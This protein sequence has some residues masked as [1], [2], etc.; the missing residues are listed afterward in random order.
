MSKHIF[1]LRL[2]PDAC[3]IDGAKFIR[4]PPPPS[5]KPYVLRLTLTAGTPACNNPILLTNYPVEERK[6][7][8]ERDYFYHIPF[9]HD[10]LG[11]ATCDVEIST[12]GVYKFTTEF[13][14]IETGERQKSL[15]SVS[16]V[17]DPCLYLPNKAIVDPKES[18][19]SKILLPLD[20]IVIL[21]LI[22]KWLP[23][24]SQW[25]SYF[26]AFAKT[27][28]NMI[29]FAPM[30]TRG[31]SNSPYAIY[32][33]LSLASEM[34]DDQISEDDKEVVLKYMLDNA[35]DMHGILSCTDIVWNHTACNSE[36][37]QD[38]P[39]A[40]Y[41]LKTAPHLRS[42]YELDEALMKFSDNVSKVYKL[43]P[44]LKTDSELG[45]IMKIF[46]QEVLPALKLWEYYVIDAESSCEEFSKAWNDPSYHVPND[47]INNIAPCSIFNFTQKDRVE[48][49]KK[50]CLLD[51]KDGK[52][53]SKTIDQ[54]FAVPFFKKWV[55][56][57]GATADS[58]V[59]PMKAYSQILNEINLL[60]YQEYDDDAACVVEQITS[61]ARYLRVQDHGPKLGSISR[62]NPLVDTYFTRLPV[63]EKTKHLHSDEMKLANN[64]WIWNAD[65]LVNFAGPKSK[66]YLRREVIAW[67]DCVKLRYGTG[68][69]DNPWL[70][71][72]IKR[73]TLKMARL[74]DGL[75]IDN[76]HSTP[77]HVASYFLDVARKHNPNIYVFAELFTGSEEK[78][79]TFVS[80]LGINSLIR[81]A[82]NA[83]E[84][85][86]LSRLAHKYGGRPSGSFTLNP[87]NI[88]LDILGHFM[89][90]TINSNK[91]IKP[92][93]I[94]IVKG[95][96]P[97]AL[98]MDCTHD[99]ETP[100]QKRTAEDT[101]PTAAIVAM[102][103]CAIGSVK[104]FDEIV[105]EL[106]N[107]VHET[108]K[109]RVPDMVEGIIPA[110]STFQSL[111]T[112]MAREG[113]N[114]VFVHHENDFVIIHRVHPITHDGYL[115]IARTAF[116]KDAGNAA[117]NP[118]RLQNQSV[119]VLEAASLKVEKSTDLK[120]N[121]GVFISKDHLSPP[122]SPSQ[123]YSHL[124]QSVKV[125]ETETPKRTRRQ[126]V[127]F[128]VITGL[129]STL[130]FSVNV[131]RFTK[132][133]IE[134]DFRGS[135]SIISIDPVE[136]TAGTVVLY[137]TWM[138]GTGLDEVEI[139]KMGTLST[140]EE[141]NGK[142]TP[143]YGA[144]ERLWSLLGYDT[145]TG[146]D[147]MFKMGWDIV[148]SGDLWFGSEKSQWPPGLM[149]A[150]LPLD[151]V[152]VNIVVFR[153]GG[154]ELNTTGDN[155]YDV[156]GY[157]SLPYCGIQGFIS[158]L[159]TIIRNND[160][161]HGLCS[162]LRAG[163]WMIDYILNRLRKHSPDYPNISAIYRW[164]EERL[165]IIS[166]LSE[167]LIPKYFALV[168]LQAYHGIRYHMVA[169]GSKTI[170]FAIPDKNTLP[171][172][173]HAFTQSL[174]MT[175][176][177]LYGRVNS[178]GLYPGK[179]PLGSHP[180]TEDKDASLAA[181]LPH[182]A[183]QHMRCWGRDIFIS[184][185]GLFLRTG[186]FAAAKE[187]I[188]S[189]GSTLRHGLI[190]NL[191]DQG[192]FPRYN[193]RDAAWWWLWS[194]QNYCQHSSEGLSFLGAKVLRRFPPLP[195][196]RFSGPTDGSEEGDIFTDRKDPGT[197]KYTSTI[198]E[199]CFEILDRHARGIKFRE[200]N[201]GGA[202]D[203][204]MADAGF[205]VAAGVKWN[206]LTGFVNGGNRYNC[207]TWM[208]K[209]GDSEKAGT[210][211]L[212]AT[213][214]DG[215]AVEIVGL[216]KATLRWVT[217]SLLVEGKKW[218]H[219]D[220]VFI[221]SENG[222]EQKVTF[223]E[224]DNMIQ[225][226]FERH[227]FIPS[228]ASDD[229]KYCIT[230][231]E[232]I[233]RRGIYR[234]VVGSSLPYTDYQFRPNIF[235]AMVVAPELFNPIHAREALKNGREILAGALGM[236]TLDPA[237]WSYRGVYDNDNDSH[238][239]KVAHGYNY[240]QGPEWVWLTGF[241][242][243]AYLQFHPAGDKVN[244]K[245]REAIQY[246]QSV[247]YEHK[248]YILDT[249][250]SKFAGLPELTNADGAYCHN[251]CDTQAWSS[252]TILEAVCD[253]VVAVAAMN[254]T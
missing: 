204:A 163:P 240:H 215:C 67:G 38:H 249:Q 149:N 7:S 218:W 188:I 197:Y 110:K 185:P 161:G 155:V 21:T 96:H 8:F 2:G 210:K 109:Y 241:F 11:D 86:E 189:F 9:K 125:S 234:D 174:M 207:G 202:L 60:Y 194:V 248:C 165:T 90:T 154:E 126:S 181:G 209:M 177:Q 68:P 147:Y 53:H 182:F 39:E 101:L 192:M 91:D 172:S 171:S 228:D 112:T 187:H 46:K 254:N 113:F 45:E 12:A 129:S 28:Y 132:T 236:K 73:Y 137:R 208:D 23:S 15:T 253:L 186:N 14:N 24:I 47:W 119:R 22:P 55:A 237:D 61:R 170:E 246:I 16:A 105:P 217:R 179:Y 214:R 251:S 250:K 54:H 106:L 134:K 138:N 70:W 36:W 229:A 98:F 77:I 80:T 178:T 233:N 190:P 74:F 200:W 144:L 94:D 152:D 79:V 146:I 247:L 139:S 42:A 221:K 148:R 143:K 35:K 162:N 3:P 31:I 150:I 5:G 34:F 64:G 244:T 130:D 115:L 17:V 145:V 211:G 56:E 169:L 117:L 151:Q 230:R 156:P 99:N 107:V 176:A 222:L 232:L 114:E 6:R 245:E 69:D 131:S 196:Y 252:A 51:R 111:H 33:Q 85:N 83:W 153:A 180:T 18:S 166:G 128:G 164:L 220:S 175:S 37:L 136:F 235:I 201:A 123:L 159:M 97:H 195:R 160:L 40:G 239:G 87:E 93:V 102:T 223:V 78:D 26:S 243:R 142:Y 4:L 30:N 95:S 168:L 191:L 84:S 41:N 82:M 167:S 238:D 52:R 120:V 44:E 173:L 227:F 13:L 118:I 183:T 127:K 157:G 184:L 205:E 71:G 135:T 72:H 59:P 19:S 122:P 124:G 75:R 92:L 108:R 49:C 1:T 216:C 25:P 62:E 224:W 203:H 50:K 116:R 88:P 121:T 57:T 158:A 58:T 43:D 29:H 81:E 193:A 225:K 100:H 133:K 10:L 89:N 213:P 66:A 32:D 48:F 219:W 212:P 104:G 65:P 140:D 20:G 242:L 27:G 199:L 76:C 198:S 231:P 226:S 103:N 206:D 63:N 141:S